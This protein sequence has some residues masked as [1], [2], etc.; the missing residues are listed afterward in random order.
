[1]VHYGVHS[2]VHF[3]FH[4]VVHLVVHFGVQLVVYFGIYLVVQRAYSSGLEDIQAQNEYSVAGKF[5][6][7]QDQ[8]EAG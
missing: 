8:V 6:V 5:H 3:G 4:S 7:A 2:V 1:M